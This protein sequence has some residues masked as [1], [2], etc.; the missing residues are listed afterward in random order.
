MTGNGGYTRYDSMQLEFRKRESHGLQFQGSYVFGKGYES[1]RFSF[2]KP[3][4]NGAMRCAK[5]SNACIRQ[6]SGKR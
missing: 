5:S 4:L 6:L 3:R 2:R 1:N